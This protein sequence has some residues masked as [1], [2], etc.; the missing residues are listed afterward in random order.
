MEIKELAEMLNKYPDIK[1][2]LKEMIE[3]VEG[4][5]HGEFSS[6]D[7]LEERTI[8]VVRNIGKDLLQNWASQQSSQTSAQIQQ[9]IPSAKKHTKK[10]SIGK[11]PLEQ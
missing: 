7:A 6:A 9:R 10:K 1:A 4:P 8:G 11:A 3:I 2:R 5:S